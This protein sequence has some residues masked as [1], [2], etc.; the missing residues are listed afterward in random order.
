MD[1]S[2][3]SFRVQRPFLRDTALLS[4]RPRRRVARP[5]R[6]A[7]AAQPRARGRHAGHA[8]LGRAQRR[9]RRA[10]FASLRDLA[11][12]PTTN[13]ALR[14]LTA[15]VTTL[16]PQLRFL[17]PYITVCNYWNIFWTFAA[18]HFSAP[19]PTGSA[20]RVL[21]NTGDRQNDSVASTLGANEHATGKRPGQARRHP[22]VRPHE[23][24]GR[25]RD[26]ARR[27][28]RTARPASRATRTARTSPDAKTRRR[29]LQA[30]GRRP[31][32]RPARRQAARARRSTKFDKQRPRH[33]AATATA[34]PEGQTF[35]DI[36]GGRARADRARRAHPRARGGS[37]G[38]EA[39]PA[40]AAWATRPSAIIAIVVAG[41]RDVPG[42]HEGDPV[43]LAL[44]G[45]GGRADREPVKP[46]S[47]VRIAGVNVGKV[48]K[49]EAVG[50]D[51]QAARVTM[52][53]RR[54]GRG[55]S[56]RTRR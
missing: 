44:R 15:T 11:T 9:A 20:Q 47:E 52:R 19:D 54:T 13:G 26:Q 29:L 22:A 37:R 16:Q 1:A 30:H 6:R 4:Q 14:G 38:H 28:A 21:L 17:G 35:T 10:S 49:I 41:R 12:T 24:R 45:R 36:P 46:G 42:V 40:S 55:R 32:Q 25:Q 8:P 23:H 48:T 51:E 27:R 33:R 53:H 18:E 3:R 2:I 43:P 7:A 34:L 39:Q 5:A 56:T 31:A 50:G